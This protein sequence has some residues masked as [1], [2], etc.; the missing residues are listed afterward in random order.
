[1][2]NETP[3]GPFPWMLTARRRT[4]WRMFAAVCILVPM[5][6]G[7]LGL[8]HH[9]PGEISDEH[10]AICH[11]QYA[12]ILLTPA[13]VIEVMASPWVAL[14]AAE[15]PDVGTPLC[16]PPLRGPPVYV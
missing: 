13:A 2:L 16:S 5:F 4:L 8:G 9:H 12:T 14:P 15:A 11:V 7:T 6:A 3:R 1:M 10:C